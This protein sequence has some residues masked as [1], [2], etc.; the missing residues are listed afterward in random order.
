MEKEQISLSFTANF[1]SLVMQKLILSLGLLLFGTSLTFGQRETKPVPE[2]WKN[3]IVTNS[4]TQSVSREDC[5]ESPYD[6]N[7]PAY[8]ETINFDPYCC[9]EDWDNICETT[10]QFFA[11]GCDAEAPY[12]NSD[13]SYVMV[14]ILDDFCCT[15]EWDE[16]CESHYEHVQFGCNANSPYG[17]TDP[18]WLQVID[19]D[20]FCCNNSWDGECQELYD[21]LAGGG[22]VGIEEAILNKTFRVYPN[23]ARNQVTARLNNVNENLQHA[24]IF[25]N[26]GVLVFEISLNNSQEQTL[27]IETLNAGIYHIQITTNKRVLTTKLL[28]D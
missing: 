2:R 24:S 8:I 21:L 17:P 10:Y 28:V 26:A 3:L 19:E 23:P 4:E 22:N 1:K 5:V 11:N 25:D 6:A 15:D 7:D 12:D 13:D 14:A 16:I 27:H 20:D 18:I 9:D